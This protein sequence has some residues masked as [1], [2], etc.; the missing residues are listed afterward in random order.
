MQGTRLFMTQMVLTHI[1][2]IYTCLHL[3]KFMGPCAIL[4][5]L[6]ISSA[7]VYHSV[8][9]EK[10]ENGGTG[11]L[12]GRGGKGGKRRRRPPAHTLS[13]KEKHTDVGIAPMPTPSLLLGQNIHL[14]PKIPLGMANHGNGRLS[15]WE[16]IIRGKPGQ[17]RS[18]NHQ[19]DRKSLWWG[20][21]V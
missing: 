12:G 6:C 17:A 9:E 1:T 14:L 19:Q 10:E 21:I 20:V 11:N 8:K 2:H 18:G 13:R 16:S 5:I 7:N 15:G 4:F 3:K